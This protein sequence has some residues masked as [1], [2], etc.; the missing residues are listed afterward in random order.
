[1]LSCRGLGALTS[2]LSLCN[3]TSYSD[4]G[5]PPCTSSVA[6]QEHGLFVECKDA[7][8]YPGKSS[9]W[10]V[11]S[12]MK[13]TAA[14]WLYARNWIW[15]INAKSNGCTG[16]E[17]QYEKIVPLDSRRALATSFTVQNVRKAVGHRKCSFLAP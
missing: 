14:P 5:V 6:V 11:T 9:C 16:L 15:M 8:C 2:P 13:G 3:T 1:M 7:S 4:C 10:G 12:E 17:D